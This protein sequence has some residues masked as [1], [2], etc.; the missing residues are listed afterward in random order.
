MNKRDY[1]AVGIFVFVE[2]DET[3]SERNGLLLPDQAKTRPNTGT[4]LSVGKNVR[5]KGIQEGRKA[6]WNRHV[7]AEIDIDGQLVTVLREDEILGVL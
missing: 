4:I 5:D 1:I 7:G 2:R 6:A 3:I